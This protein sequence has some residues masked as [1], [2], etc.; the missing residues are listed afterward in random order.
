MPLPPL[1]RPGLGD[2]GA[3]IL[4]PLSFL[5]TPEQW[6][7]NVP[8][9]AYASRSIDYVDQA[10]PTRDMFSVAGHEF[11]LWLLVIYPAQQ[12]Y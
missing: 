3:F 9:L 2:Y 5:Y 8:V 11:T 7:E 12:P 6:L 1:L 10:A 4:S